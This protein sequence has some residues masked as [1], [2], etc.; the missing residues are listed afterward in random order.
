MKIQSLLLATYATLAAS[1]ALRCKPHEHLSYHRSNYTLPGG[2]LASGT[3]SIST[4]EAIASYGHSTPSSLPL[5]VT[6]LASL[7]RTTGPIE[8][9]SSSNLPVE[10]S[11]PT[12]TAFVSVSTTTA[13]TVQPTSPTISL[14]AV[15]S[16]GV[17]ETVN[18]DKRP[19]KGMSFTNQDVAQTWGQKK[20]GWAYN[21]WTGRGDIPK[22]MEYYP[23]VWCPTKIGVDGW[24]NDAEAAIASGSKHLLGFN[25]PD[26]HGQCDIPVE[27]AVEGYK[28]YMNKFKGRALLG[29]PAVTN[30]P[31]PRGLD[32]LSRFLDQCG[33]D[34]HVDFL[35]THWYG[36]EQ[37]GVWNFQRHVNKTIEL[38]EKHGISQVYITEFGMT[39]ADVETTSSFIEE[40]VPWLDQNEAV[41]GY[42]YFGFYDGILMKGDA[43][44]EL[45]Q[46]YARAG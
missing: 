8:H 25:E 44:S 34:C 1:R 20:I 2:E 11:L 3:P 46:A 4:D 7:T 17:P 12:T 28:S 41:G 10:T 14:V 23:M 27:Q 40:V 6:T 16:S 22:E 37:N 38:A 5:N 9:H 32:Y 39:G 29:S 21:W 36:V 35:V 26:Q 24:T 19:K 30:N 31:A 45:G 15:K 33:N 13:T 43:I 18:S 42:A